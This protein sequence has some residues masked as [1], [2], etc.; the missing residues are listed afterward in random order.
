[1]NILVLDFEGSLAAGIR[2]IGSIYAEGNEIISYEDKNIE[3]DQECIGILNKIVKKHPDC[4]ISHNIHI[5]KNLL[6]KYLPYSRQKKEHLKVEWGPWLDT[7]NIYN[8]LYPQLSQY[9]LTF[10]TKTFVQKKAI[11]LS[12]KYCNKDKSRHHF[13]L[14]DAICTFLLFERIQ[15]KV[16][17]N[18]FIQ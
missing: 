9:N 17:L 13:A 6:K 15:S 11:D 7:K 1:M 4:F 12:K 14:Y 2:E 3:D 16:D 5:E 8:A 18:K 10:L